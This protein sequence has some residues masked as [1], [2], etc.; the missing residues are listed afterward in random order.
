[1]IGEI[2][3]EILKEIKLGTGNRKQGVLLGLGN[4]E[5]FGKTGNEKRESRSKE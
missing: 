5:S 3:E 4:R 1:L 2:I